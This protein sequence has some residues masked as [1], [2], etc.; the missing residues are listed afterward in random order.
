MAGSL[1]LQIF[2]VAAVMTL[3]PGKLCVFFCFLLQLYFPLDIHMLIYVNILRKRQRAVSVIN[4]R[5]QE[6]R[7]S[8]FAAGEQLKSLTTREVTTPQEQGAALT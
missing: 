8:R 4:K 1:V 5:H 3:P 2:A 6:S 7:L